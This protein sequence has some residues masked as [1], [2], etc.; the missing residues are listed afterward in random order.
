M[1]FSE[2]KQPGYPSFVGKTNKGCKGEIK[3]RRKEGRK[4]G[5]F[6]FGTHYLL[7]H[8]NCQRWLL[9]L[10]T[11][12]VGGKWEEDDKCSRVMPMPCSFKFFVKGMFERICKNVIFFLIVF[13]IIFELKYLKP[14]ILKEPSVVPSFKKIKQ[15][16]FRVIFCYFYETFQ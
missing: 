10:S 2:C 4:E 8:N 3:E 1:H 6:S 16:S 9:L 11:Y 5:E 7:Q 15:G 12:S 13:E 14:E